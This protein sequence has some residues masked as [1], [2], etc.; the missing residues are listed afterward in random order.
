MESIWNRLDYYDFAT[1][2]VISFNGPCFPY[3]E[4]RVDCEKVKQC[5]I[6]EMCRK[7]E[8]RYHLEKEAKD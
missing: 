6:W 4:V 2:I 7:N 3:Y 5:I 1:Q 8:K